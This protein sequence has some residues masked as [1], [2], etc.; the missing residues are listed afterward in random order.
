MM[1]ITFGLLYINIILVAN[2]ILQRSI[3]LDYD[4]GVE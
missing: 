1:C 3:M 4:C 2:Y